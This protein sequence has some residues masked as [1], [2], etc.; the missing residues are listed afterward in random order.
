MNRFFCFCS[1]N[2]LVKEMSFSE[3]HFSLPKSPI[4]TNPE[5]RARGNAPR[6]HTLTQRFHPRL[7]HRDMK[8]ENLSSFCLFVLFFL[9]FC[10]YQN[11]NVKIAAV[12]IEFND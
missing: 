3:A 8:S 7:P 12:I 9:E 10:F 1:R 5:N 2:N 11:G 4:V 6:E